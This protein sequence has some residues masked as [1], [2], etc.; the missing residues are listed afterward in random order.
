MD[1]RKQ[2][3][4]IE[5]TLMSQ[6]NSRLNYYKYRHNHKI[7]SST[8]RI[9]KSKLPASSSTTKVEVRYGAGVEEILKILHHTSQNKVKITIKTP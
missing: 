7:L 8:E 9:Y 6:L 4:A 3:L 1:S 5:D 2:D